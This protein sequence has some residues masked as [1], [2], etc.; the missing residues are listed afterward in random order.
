MRDKVLNW[1]RAQAMT[2][3]GQTVI[4]AVSGGADSVCMLHVLLA[5]RSVLGLTIEAAH[6]NHCLR[7]Q[8]ADRDEAFVRALCQTLGVSLHVGR[9]D[10]RARAAETHES[11]EEAA[12]RLRY[13]FFATLPGLVATAHTQDDNLETVL[14]N[15]TRGTGLTG[16]CGIPPKRGSYIRPML[17]LTRAEIEAYLAQNS[18]TYVTDSTNLLPDVRRNRLRQTVIPLLKEENPSVSQT[19]FRMCRLLE[20]D[21]AC[22]SSQAQATMQHAALADGVSCRA[23]TPLPDAVRTRAVKQLLSGIHA[24]KL[25]EKHICAVDRL[26]SSVSPSAQVSLPGGF[27]AQRDYDRLYLR[28]GAAADGFAPVTLRPG[29]T[30]VLP[31]CGVRV[32]CRMQEIFSEFQNTLSTFAIKCDTIESDIRLVLRPR[33][34]HDVMRT[35]GGHKT[36]KKLFI[37][38]RISAAQ[39]SRLPVVADARGVLGVYGIGINLDHAAAIGGRAI[40]ITIEELEKE[41]LLYD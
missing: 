25:S 20:A 41:D 26:L 32:Q 39:R 27:T 3:P 35:A 10:V 34:A 18:L 11:I 14:L 30:V 16:L 40:I 31:A 36:L 5:L 24:P 29:E 23:L 7:G 21:D 33:Q 38:R 15:L 12:R 22:L 19:V 8:E 17:V 28:Q 6:F 4:C 37:E 13:E 9:G 1:M 2:R